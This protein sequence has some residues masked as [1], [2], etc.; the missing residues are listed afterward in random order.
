M[1]TVQAGTVLQTAILD[2]QDG[3]WYWPD[4]TGLGDR[5]HV[6]AIAYVPEPY[7]RP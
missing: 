7:Q 1:A 5:E 4:G 6:I 3:I 2:V